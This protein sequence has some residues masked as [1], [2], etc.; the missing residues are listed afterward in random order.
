MAHRSFTDSLARKWDVWNVTPT[1]AERRDRSAPARPPDPPGIERRRQSEYRVLLGAEWL[2]GWLTFETNGQKRRLADF[3]QDWE[4]LSASDLE[5]LC[6]R[7]V[8]VAPS[9]RLVE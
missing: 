3:P 6:E 5:Q 7:A 1:K 8:E 4:Q 9:R 2:K